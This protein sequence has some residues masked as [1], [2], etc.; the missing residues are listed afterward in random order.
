MSGL[1][2]RHVSFNSNLKAIIMKTIKVLIVTIM[3]ILLVSS[4][5]IMAQ[6]EKKPVSKGKTSHSETTKPKTSSQT[7][8]SDLKGAKE[9]IWGEWMKPVGKLEF[10]TLPYPYDALEP[11]I[12]K[13]TVE[14]HYERHHRGYFDKMQK[15]VSG[16]DAAEKNLL[17]IFSHMDKFP[18]AVRNNSGGFFN[19]ALYWDNLTP[20]KQ[21]PSRQ[22]IELIEKSFGNYDSFVKKFDE[23]AANR[24][25]SGWAWLAVD[26]KSGELFITST[27]NQD[28]P[29]MSIAERRGIPLL[30][31]DVW[32]HAYYL[33][34]QNKRTDYINSF[35]SVV[36]WPVVE[37]RY[38]QFKSI[39]EKVK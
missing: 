2:A 22:M 1:V 12:D 14:I 19:H 18:D 32:E 21:E 8:A 11:A 6:T 39:M 16:T 37:A 4:P 38:N 34:Y 35:W 23:A 7:V 10:Y 29:L 27:A 25:G 26:I 28:N 31:L 3:C 20:K 36:N 15:A 9:G 13:M 24:F 17:E 33:K 30:A 5:E